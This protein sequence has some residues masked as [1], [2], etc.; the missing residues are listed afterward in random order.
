MFIRAIIPEDREQLIQII[1][2]QKNFLQCEIDIATEVIDETFNPAEDYQA[3]AAFDNDRRLLGFISFGPIPLT[4]NRFDIYWIAVDPDNGRH[5]TGTVLLTEMENRL[6]K[7]GSGHIYVETSSTEGYLPA[8]LFYEKNNYQL[9]SHL[10]DF[11]RDGDD[12]MIYR[13]IY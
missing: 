1:V 13:K 10:K 4:V 6:K 7:S 12:R 5:G 2:K 9:V 3:L 8:R 11:Y